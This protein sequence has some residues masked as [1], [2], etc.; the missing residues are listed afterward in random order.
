MMKKMKEKIVVN[1]RIDC[2]LA[3]SLEAISED[4]FITRSTLIRVMLT[5]C[6][7]EVN[8]IKVTGGDKGEII[9]F[10]SDIRQ[11]EKV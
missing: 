2:E 8:L 7:D 6:V 4:L 3:A 5:K 11:D 9:K 1:S 10:L